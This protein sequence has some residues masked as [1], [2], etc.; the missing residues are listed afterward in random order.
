MPLRSGD[1][2]V[3]DG[4]D[5]SLIN[6]TIDPAVVRAWRRHGARVLS[7]EGL[8]AKVIVFEM[9]AEP[10]VLITG[11]ANVSATSRDTRLEAFI[12][13]TDPDTVEAARQTIHSWIAE[14]GDPLDDAWQRRAAQLFRPPPQLPRYRQRTI[15]LSRQRL[16]LSVADPDD[17]GPTATVVAARESSRRDWSDATVDSW[18]LN[19]GDEN[20][21]ACGDTLV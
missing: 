13:T 18:T 10:A 19:P 21:V 2:I 12:A 7:L 5:L 8:H 4:S 11:S 3:V 20:L 1:S 9:G 6:G 16:W 17:T 14:A 15:P